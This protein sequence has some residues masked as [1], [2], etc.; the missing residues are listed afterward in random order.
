MSGLD[1]P[2]VLFAAERTLMAWSRT[3]AGLMAFGF[4][5]DRT[6]VLLPGAAPR[7]NFAFW[8]GLAFVLLGVLLSA[9]SILQYRRS[10][11]SLRPVEIPPGYWVNMSVYASGV[12][13]LLGVALALYLI[14]G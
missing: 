2:R 8:I 7:P 9:L 12:I 5:V 4:L 10:V 1:D 11:A 13:G 14:A 3:A 6:S